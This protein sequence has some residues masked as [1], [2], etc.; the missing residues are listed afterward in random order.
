VKIIVPFG[1]APNAAPAFVTPSLLVL[2]SDTKLQTPTICA[3]GSAPF[4][5]AQAV[6]VTHD[7]ETAIADKAKIAVAKLRS[8]IVMEISRS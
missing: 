1:F 6:G 5:C 3:F 8:Y 4:C 2:E 7:K